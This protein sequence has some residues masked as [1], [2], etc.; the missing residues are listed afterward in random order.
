M[1]I[2]DL[3]FHMVH[4]L[5]RKHHYFCCMVFLK[6]FLSLYPRITFQN[7]TLR[8][9]PIEMYS[10]AVAKALVSVNL[11]ERG[12]HSSPFLSIKLNRLIILLLFF[13][14]L[15]AQKIIAD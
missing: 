3:E 7:I 13:L 12:F 15:V 11:R 14:F 2:R 8:T 1:Q 10:V 9:R 4:L 6:P 5:C